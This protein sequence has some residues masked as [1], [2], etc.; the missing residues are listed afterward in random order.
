M[1]EKE[2]N[3]HIKKKLVYKI[4][5]KSSIQYIIVVV[6]FFK[7]YHLSLTVTSSFI[8]LLTLPPRS[9]FF[10]F[11]GKYLLRCLFGPSVEVFTDFLSGP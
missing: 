9:F 6:S 1:I 7:G 3:F 11:S 5:I 4:E 10:Y 8:H 2:I